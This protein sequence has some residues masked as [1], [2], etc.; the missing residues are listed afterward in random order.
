MLVTLFYQNT[1]YLD[2]KSAATDGGM[3]LIDAA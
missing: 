3:V 1:V 2:V